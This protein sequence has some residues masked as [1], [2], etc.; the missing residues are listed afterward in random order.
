MKEYTLN[1]LGTPW[2]LKEVEKQNDPGLKEADGYTDRSTKTMVVKGEGSGDANDLENYPAY[3]KEIKRHEIVHAFLYE[4][5]LGADYEH[6]RWGHD[7]TAVDWIA[8]QFPKLQEAF[9]A[10]DAI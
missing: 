5:G 6:P 3:L 4:S 1:I 8:L 9:K 7:E 2:L 10:A